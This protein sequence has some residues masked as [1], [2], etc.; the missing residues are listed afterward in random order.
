[1]NIK[2]TLANSD[3]TKAEVLLKQ[4]TSKTWPIF[5]MIKIQDIL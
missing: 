5:N 2:I 1:M 3:R 4:A